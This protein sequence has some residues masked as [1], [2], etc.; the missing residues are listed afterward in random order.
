MRFQ[1]PLNK[2]FTTI[3]F[4]CLAMSAYSQSGT[5]AKVS[6]SSVQ[7]SA[8]YPLIDVHMQIAA[9]SENK[10]VLRWAPVAGAISHYVLERSADRRNYYEA[11]VLFT[12]NGEEEPEYVYTDKLPRAYPGAIY[13]RL[14]I[15]GLDGMEA[16]TLP[17]VAQS[18][19]GT[20]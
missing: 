17:V 16:Y 12:A 10:I 8:K 18:I 5:Y 13:Y 1:Y 4:A 15:I 9:R 20:K 14:R 19:Q 2:I 11:A 7:A 3:A 6:A